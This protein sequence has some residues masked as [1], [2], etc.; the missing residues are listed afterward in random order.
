MLSGCFGLTWTAL[1]S[2]ASV[3]GRPSI[4]TA[5]DVTGLPTYAAAGGAC[6]SAGRTPIAPSTPSTPITSR[7]LRTLERSPDADVDGKDV[8]ARL[9]E[10]PPEAIRLVVLEHDHLVA[11]SRRAECFRVG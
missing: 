3:V 1:R 10:D 6:A 9:R 2:D 11:V 5:T 8:G 7:T 4:E